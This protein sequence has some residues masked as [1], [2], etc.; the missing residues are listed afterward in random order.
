MAESPVNFSAGLPETVLPS[1]DPELLLE[2]QV[3]LD[4][5]SDER[6]EKLADIV[7]RDPTFMLGWATLSQAA[8]DDI[9]GYAYARVGYH[10]GLDAIRRA[11]WKGSGYVRWSE[12]TNRGFLLALEQL[13]LRADAIGESIEA[14][15]CDLFLRQLD[16]DWHGLPEE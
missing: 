14:Q 15:R 12:P 5:E 8:R 4:F 1:V 10:R 7:R 2:L 6:R 3:A 16:P 9:E 11:G 13:R